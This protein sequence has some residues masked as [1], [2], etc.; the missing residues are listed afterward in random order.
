MNARRILLLVAG[1]GSI[2]LFASPNASAIVGPAREGGAFAD[3][4]V[5]V[6]TRG[7]EG[8]GFCSGVVLAPR[9]VLTA[10]HC[11]HP[12]SDMLVYYKDAD[13]KPVLVPVAAKA[14]H[15][16]FHADAVKQ[17]VVSIDLGLIET[18]TP[19]PAAF[20]PAVLA[21]GEAPSVGDGATVV[22][23]GIAHEGEPKTGGS[24]RAASLKVR[25]PASEILLWADD[26]DGAGAGGCSGDSGAPIFAADGQSVV[27]IVA[28]TSGAA[29]HKC[30]AIT[31]GPL[32]APLRAWIASTIDR[33]RP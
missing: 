1:V 24:L 3:R 14:A 9:I 15:P 20:R 28:W 16:Q 25:A 32:V 26:P 23:Y 5:M 21:E 7:A 18:E 2:A 19:L 33:W 17:R 29:G 11:L 22:G 13:G 8:S 10:A 6:L 12:A 30:G 31:Q 4:I 27:A